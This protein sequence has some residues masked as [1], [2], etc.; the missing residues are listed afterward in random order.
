MI[1]GMGEPTMNHFENLL[2]L[3]ATKPSQ[4]EAVFLSIGELTAM[5]HFSLSDPRSVRYEDY[6][7]FLPTDDKNFFELPPTHEFPRAFYRGWDRA[8]IR[9]L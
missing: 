1:G 6:Y 5:I 2:E 3:N 4:A 9:S 8:W 7:T